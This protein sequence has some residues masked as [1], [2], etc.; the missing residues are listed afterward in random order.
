MNRH[1]HNK[2]QVL[3]VTDQ[4]TSADKLL[5]KSKIFVGPMFHKEF[6]EKS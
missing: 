4:Q 1:I 5:D 6:D 3:V 2:I